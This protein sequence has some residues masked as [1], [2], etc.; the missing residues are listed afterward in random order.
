MGAAHFS[1]FFFVNN[2]IKKLF[3]LVP[4][5]HRTRFVRREIVDDWMDGSG[6]VLLVGDAAHP[7]MVNIPLDHI[8][9][10]AHYFFIALFDAK[11]QSCRGR[12]GC[13]WWPDVPFEHIRTNT[14][15]LRSVL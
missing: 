10:V 5:A 1:S 4:T 15:I 13:S 11:C 3:N 7:L 6:R 9:F 12:R 8:Y 14:A 2:R